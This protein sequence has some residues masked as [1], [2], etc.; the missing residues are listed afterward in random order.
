MRRT[1]NWFIVAALA[2]AGTAIGVSAYNAGYS[3]GL[4]VHGAVQVVRDVGPGFGFFP[5]LFI[6][7]FFILFF[8]FGRLG[9]RAYRRRGPWS[10]HLDEWHRQEHESE[11]TH[12]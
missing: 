1:W 10:G 8:G 5:F 7:L 6:P 4:A 9:R 2:I 12:R 11:T 3:H